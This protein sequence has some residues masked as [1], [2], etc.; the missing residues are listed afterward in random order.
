MEI[1]SF[2]ARKRKSKFL[3]LHCFCW[4]P[5]FTSVNTYYV[6]S[7][8][9]KIRQKKKLKF[10]WNHFFQ[11]KN[12]NKRRIRSNFAWSLFFATAARKRDASE[13]NRV[14]FTI[15]ICKLSR[16]CLSHAGTCLV[17]ASP[18]AFDSLATRSLS[19]DLCFCAF[20]Y[21]FIIIK[22]KTRECGLYS[23]LN[24]VR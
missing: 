13:I 21:I 15:S 6:R 17:S 19:R 18:I 3:L 24:T 5:L 11:R 1:C 8:F 4:Q 10:S 12:R 9:V 2:C 23:S 7:L 14:F 22:D 20:V 16:Y